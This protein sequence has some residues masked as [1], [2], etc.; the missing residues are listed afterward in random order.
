MAKQLAPAARELGPPGEAPPA[1]T[2]DA[3]L[4]ATPDQLLDMEE[5]DPANLRKR[6][7]QALDHF[8]ESGRLRPSDLQL[9][10]QLSPYETSVHSLT[11]Y[12]GGE[13]DPERL[14]AACIVD[15][16]PSNMNPTSEPGLIELRMTARPRK[17]KSAPN[18]PGKYYKY[19]LEKPPGGILVPD[20]DA[21][22]DN[23]REPFVLMHMPR[24]G[25]QTRVAVLEPT[26]A[27][28]VAH[29]PAD[30]PS[31]GT[32]GAASEITPDDLSEV[33]GL[34][35]RLSLLGAASN[36]NSDGGTGGALG[37]ALAPK[38]FASEASCAHC[39]K[40][41][42]E[43]QRCSRCKQ[44]CYCGAECQRAGWKAHKKTCA[45][46]L[47]WIQVAEKVLSGNIAGDWR[48]ILKWE[49]RMEELLTHS[50]D[51][52][53]A[54]CHLQTFMNAHM[55]KLSTTG[56]QKS[57]VDVARLEARRV[58]LLGKMERKAMCNLAFH[59][60]VIGKKEDA[61]RN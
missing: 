16:G 17:G 1:R 25:G 14:G 48:E 21:G 49:G 6:F 35:E 33:T 45:P 23:N 32:F 59:L 13:F 47:H 53:I 46:P 7:K 19:L 15:G 31:T 28:D 42:G 20:P 8:H 3:L 26:T 30:A 56:F 57:A 52:Q 39:G 38:T 4:Y 43:F 54:N 10:I 44:A 22:P 40:Q 60:V 37:G 2:S 55:W 36:L 29:T 50:P 61:A 9:P 27:V 18:L 41:G 11:G 58:D 24:R 51:D 12:E 34:V 5:R